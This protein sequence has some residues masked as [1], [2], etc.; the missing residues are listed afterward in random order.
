MFFLLALHTLFASFLA[1][2]PF[3]GAV[4]GAYAQSVFQSSRA[5]RFIAIIWQADSEPKAAIYSSTPAQHRPPCLHSGSW[6]SFFVVWTWGF[7]E[8]QAIMQ[9]QTCLSQVPYRLRLSSQDIWDWSS[10][11]SSLM[12]HVERWCCSD[13]LP[14]GLR[15]FFFFS[16]KWVSGKH[17]AR[18]KSQPKLGIDAIHPGA[19]A[20]SGTPSRKDRGGGQRE[21]PYSWS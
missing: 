8:E 2:L 15:G 12:V 1:H 13:I 11:S 6:F 7:R 16:K 17:V 4:L 14:P 5:G 9:G 18:W 19:K 10:W 21:I 3:L 20:V